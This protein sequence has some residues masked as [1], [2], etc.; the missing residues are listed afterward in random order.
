M[1]LL[2][3]NMK[4]LIVDNL[5]SN[6]PSKPLSARCGKL[7]KSYID[8]KLNACYPVGSIYL[9][10]TLNRSLNDLIDKGDL[11]CPIE[12]ILGGKWQRVDICIHPVYNSNFALDVLNSTFENSRNVQIYQNN[13]SKGQRWMWSA[14]DYKTA[15]DT[16]P[17]T[18]QNPDVAPNGRGWIAMWVRIA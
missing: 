3:Q 13:Q 5:D 2:L 1:N 15:P 11:V 9:Y 16:P 14:W 7:L 10:S 6:D 8:R 17:T 4:R 18:T 12:K